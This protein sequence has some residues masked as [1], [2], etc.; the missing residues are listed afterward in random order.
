MRNYVIE[1]LE[2]KKNYELAM[3]MEETNTKYDE[4]GPIITELSI[5]KDGV[6][7]LRPY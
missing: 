2:R 3:I 6:C 7:T 4:L 1:V 5:L